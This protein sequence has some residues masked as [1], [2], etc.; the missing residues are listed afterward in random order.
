MFKPRSRRPLGDRRYRAEIAAYRLAHALGLDNVPRAVPRSFDVT[1][2]RRLLP[3]FDKDALPDTDGR[4]RGALMPWIDAYRVLPLEEA[5]W[6]ARWEPWLTDPSSTI[7][8]DQRPLAAAISTLIAFDYITANWDRWSGA[9]IAEDGATHAVLYVDND[10][11]F[12]DNPPPHALTRQLALLR[13]VVRFSSSFV[14]A[15]RALDGAKLRD[16]F[17][18]ETPG[19]P[20]LLDRAVKD[21]DARRRTVLDAIDS[22]VKDA[23][24]TAVLA[25]P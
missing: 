9:N 16:T 19:Q 21:A 3:D 23:G 20:L 18:E 7:P 1:T 10:G 15:L 17:G 2:L 6:R 4:I 13:R 12:Y 8:E 14:E 5:S 22:R 25:F 24:A 11:A